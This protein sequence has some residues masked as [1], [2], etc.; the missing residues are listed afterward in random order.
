M[1]KNQRLHAQRDDASVHERGFGGINPCL[2]SWKSAEADSLVS[3]KGF[4]ALSR[5]LQPAQ[6]SMIKNQRLTLNGTTRPSMNRRDK[7]LPQFVEVR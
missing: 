7:S 6:S 1:I 4:H 3:P 5:R 2:S